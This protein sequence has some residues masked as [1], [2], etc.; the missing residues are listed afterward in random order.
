MRLLCAAGFVS[1][2]GAGCQGPGHAPATTTRTPPAASVPLLIGTA[3]VGWAQLQPY[4][5][6]T[7]GRQAIEEL[8]LDRELARQLEAAGIALTDDLLA[9]E[10]AMFDAG[11]AGSPGT[12]LQIRRSR[13]LGPHRLERLLRRNA[14]LRALVGEPE[15]ATE[16]EVRFAHELRHGSRRVLRVMVIPDAARAG[17]IRESLGEHASLEGLDSSDPLEWAFARAAFE[18]SADPSAAAGGL[19]GAVHPLDPSL[20][21]AVRQAVLDTPDGSL[22][23]LIL[24]DRGSVLV[25]PIGTTPANEITLG[26]S[27]S[28][29]IKDLRVQRQRLIMDDRAREILRQARP[30]VLDPGLNW[31]WENARSGR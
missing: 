20:P 2:L 17:Q 6:E 21:E 10:R 8:I 12:M 23:M 24:T 26:E 3:A 1:A 25:L 27:R 31:A 16:D 15:T 28:E 14:S 13:G 18:E 30:T 11:A 29:I 5:T 22:S 7:G 9:K 4:L 19:L